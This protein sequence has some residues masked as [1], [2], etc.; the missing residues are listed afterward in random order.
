MTEWIELGIFH[1]TLGMVVVFLFSIIL[2]FVVQVTNSLL[3]IVKRVT[4]PARKIFKVYRNEV[5]A[6]VIS[7][8][9]FHHKLYREDRFKPIRQAFVKGRFN[10]RWNL[11]GKL[12]GISFINDARSWLNGLDWTLSSKLKFSKKNVGEGYERKKS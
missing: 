11:P 2:G 8:I 5:L 10:D 7:S 6:G 9:I 1:L 3:N 12:R 4:S